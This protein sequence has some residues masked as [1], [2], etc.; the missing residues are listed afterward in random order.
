MSTSIAINLFFYNVGVAAVTHDVTIMILE[1]RIEKLFTCKI[2][3]SIKCS[4]PLENVLVSN[5]TEVGSQLTL[6][7][8]SC[9]KNY[10]KVT[11][12]GRRPVPSHHK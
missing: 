5:T 3:E 9:S 7:Y 6:L 11:D 10:S 1:N 4:L 12:S 8:Q 2:K